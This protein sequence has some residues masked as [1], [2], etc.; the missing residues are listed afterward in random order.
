MKKSNDF[1]QKV[2]VVAAHPDD[3]V[4][5]CGATMAK[6]A[7][8][9]DMVAVLILAEGITARAVSREPGEHK[10]ELGD[11]AQAAQKAND[12]LGVFS[13]KLHTFPDNRMDSVDRLDVIKV[14]EEA[15]KLHSPDI[16]Y[17]HHAGDVNI[18]HRRVQ[19]AVIAA[20]RPMPGVCVKRLLFFEVASSTE[21]QPPSS[22]PYFQPQWFENV[23]DTLH[24]KLQALQAYASEMREFPHPRSIKSLEYLARWRG[25]IVGVDAAEAFVL[26]REICGKDLN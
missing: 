7:K 8:N 13:L 17:T 22:G 26:G 4:L 3:E 1:K 12:I 14:V 19:E 6:H 10:H 23:S 21:W 25:S 2:L 5:G 9:G 20:C 15:I 16:V 11:L 18:D 24:L